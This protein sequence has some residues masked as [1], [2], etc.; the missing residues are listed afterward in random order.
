M[1]E[2]NH[3]HRRYANTQLLQPPPAPEPEQV[4]EQKAESK[5]VLWPK[6][7]RKPK[8]KTESLPPGYDLLMELTQTLD[9]PTPWYELFELE[10]VRDLT[11]NIRLALNQSLKAEINDFKYRD[12]MLMQSKLDAL[13]EYIK[14]RDLEE[15]AVRHC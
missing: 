7:K 13:G 10:T 12:V 14:K 1:D 11:A 6:P 9:D 4:L 5:Q 8:P 15:Y 3:F 2:Q